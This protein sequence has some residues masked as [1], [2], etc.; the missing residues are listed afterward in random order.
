MLLQ[1]EEQV[2][3]MHPLGNVSFQGI[4]L[5]TSGAS[6]AS[7]I[8][9]NT[10]ANITL[11]SVPTA[12][13]SIAFAGIETS[14]SGINIGGASAG[15]GNIIGSNTVNSSI[16]VTTT[17]ATATF[18]TTI[19]GISCG[20]TGGLVIGNQV[21]GIDIK[22]IGT[23]PAPSTFIGINI[24]NATAPSQVNNNIIGSTGAGAASNSIRVLSTSTATKTAIT[25]I[26]IAA[27]VTSAV[28]VDGNIIQNLSHLSTV[29]TLTAGGVIGI[30]NASTGASAINDNKQYGYFTFI[31]NLYYRCI[32]W[33]I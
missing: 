7:N 22:N 21:A 16:S 10:I 25:G 20:S 24:S 23:A 27:T 2:P 33:N 11:S 15:D 31:L 29:T 30:S 3:P 19:R 17:T 4:L 1:Q 28:Q 18:T 8:K 5:T 13:G 9:G 12:A 32:L 14:G 26:A 6:P